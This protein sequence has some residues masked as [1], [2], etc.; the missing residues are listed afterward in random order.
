MR[1]NLASSRIRLFHQTPVDLCSADEFSTARPCNVP[2]NANS[3]QKPCNPSP[4]LSSHSIPMPKGQPLGFGD[5]GSKP[6]WRADAMLVDIL[7]EHWSRWTRGCDAWKSVLGAANAWNTIFRCVYVSRVQSPFGN[8]AAGAI[9]WGLR[10]ILRS[11]QV[12]RASIPILLATPCQ[13]QTDTQSPTSMSPH[14]SS[15]TSSTR[16]QFLKPV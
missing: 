6:L 1:K 16:S 5:P 4:L 2:P 14:T 10:M 15:S 13:S 9:L 11:P 8:R 12:T 3:N 7:L